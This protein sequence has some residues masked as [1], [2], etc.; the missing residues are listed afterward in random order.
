MESMIVSIIWQNQLCVLKASTSVV[1]ILPF[2]PLW[3]TWVSTCD[4]GS[5]TWLHWALK[6]MITMFVWI[7]RYHVFVQCDNVLICAVCSDKFSNCCINWVV[8]LGRQ[9]L[10]IDLLTPVWLMLTG[11]ITCASWLLYP[12][13]CCVNSR[14]CCQIHSWLF[15]FLTQLNMS[16]YLS[17]KI[18]LLFFCSDVWVTLAWC[19][20]DGFRYMNS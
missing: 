9:N 6:G 14:V 1:S 13:V 19:N 10:L 5:V 8:S 7:T 15:T 16:F 20:P 18:P 4:S 3:N 17:F 11:E 12:L 2:V